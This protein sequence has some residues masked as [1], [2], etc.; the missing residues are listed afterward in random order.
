[1]NV[2]TLITGAAVL[3]VIGS[4][5]A[6]Q[7]RN[8]KKGKSACSCCGSCAGCSM[9]GSCHSTQTSNSCK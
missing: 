2:P 7:I 9:C 3:L 6:A 4:V 8:H 5:I 1:M